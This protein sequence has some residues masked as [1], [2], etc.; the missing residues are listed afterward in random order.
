MEQSIIKIF[1]NYSS[2]EINE[3]IEYLEQYKHDIEKKKQ[4]LTELFNYGDLKIKLIQDLLEIEEYEQMIFRDEKMILKLFS[5]VK[6]IEIYKKYI[7]SKYMNP[8]LCDSLALKLAC[9]LDNTELVKQYLQIPEITISNGKNSKFNI[10]LI[11]D[12]LNIAIDN[13]NEEL[14]D[15]LLRDSRIKITKSNWFNLFKTNQYTIEYYEKLLSNI[16]NNRFTLSEYKNMI[17]IVYR[18]RD[19]DKMKFLLQENKFGNYLNISKHI[20][21][22]KNIITKL[23][24]NCFEYGYN[25]CY[26][27]LFM[28]ALQ[29][30]ITKYEAKKI[31][32]QLFQYK[33]IDLCEKWIIKC[34]KYLD[35]YNILNKFLILSLNNDQ[36]KFILKYKLYKFKY[37]KIKEIQ[38]FRED[39]DIEDIGIYVNEYINYLV[40]MRE[41]EQ[42]EYIVN[43]IH[44]LVIIIIDCLLSRYT[45]EIG[46]YLFQQNFKL[47][48][49]AIRQNMNILYKYDNYTNGMNT[50]FGLINEIDKD[51]YDELYNMYHKYKNINN[52]TEFIKHINNQSN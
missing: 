11:P 51:M 5:T 14:I 25:P 34:I 1:K 16:A 32:I 6:S 35:N 47:I 36:F 33:K 45:H 8:V 7:N 30:N 3:F 12:P 20:K 19:V 52:V 37:D 48:I 39:I 49:T 9:K 50:L 15:L 10:Y 22:T 40:S 29:E 17:I 38:Y 42:N 44:N 24:I 26:D 27:I 46:K 2:E 4:L 41:N 18:W 31:L 28:S 43:K 21:T 23:M 13:K